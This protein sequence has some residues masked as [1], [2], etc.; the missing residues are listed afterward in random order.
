ME[1]VKVWNPFHFEHYKYDEC[2]I[3]VGALI[4]NVANTINPLIKNG[5]APHGLLTFYSRWYTMED[6]IE[7]LLL[8][9]FRQV[10]ELEW[11]KM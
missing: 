4:Y 1:T 3:E 7:T 6:V 8:L 9:G 11:S 5:K 10:N 2:F